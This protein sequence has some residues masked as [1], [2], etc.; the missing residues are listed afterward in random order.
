MLATAL[1]AGPKI[2]F[3]KTSHDF[4]NIDKGEKKSVDFE[5]KNTGDEP[6]EILDVQTSCGC[7]S[8]KPEKSAYA[9]GEVGV[10]PV[11]FDSGRFSG[12]IKKTITVT[13]N[14]TENERISLA[15][16]GNIVSEVNI[17]PAILSMYNI[18]RSAND[19]KEIEISTEKLAKLQITGA[20]SNLDFLDITIVPK[21]DKTV[22][23]KA[24][25]NGA[26]APKEQPAFRGYVDIKTNSEKRPEIKVPVNIKFEEPVRVLPRFISFYGSKADQNREMTLTL[27]PTTDAEFSIENV[28]TDLE[29]VDVSTVSTDGA[30]KRVV[31][32]L[33]GGDAPK[34]KFSGHVTIKTNLEDQPEV[35]IPVRGNVM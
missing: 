22:I 20:T 30:N 32:T 35:R 15:I 1:F 16:E 10:I 27:S 19:V 26:K 28:S 8:A 3:T 29:F 6:L 5:F 21:D 23:V 25:V 12:K 2:E 14:A 34:N 18:K 31:V 33:R 17:Q 24:M 13:T 7:T 11:T 9:P 4:E